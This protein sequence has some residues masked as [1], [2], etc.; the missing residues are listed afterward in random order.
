MKISGDGSCVYADSHAQAYVQAPTNKRLNTM[1]PPTGHATQPQ[2]APG[3]R[4]GGM[5][6]GIAPGMACTV[7]SRPAA[8]ISARCVLAMR[9]ITRSLNTRKDSCGALVA[10]AKFKSD[11]RRRENKTCSS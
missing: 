7:H 1:S 4:Q 3:N 6:T 9:G 2:R 5:R 11:Y 10:L 8:A